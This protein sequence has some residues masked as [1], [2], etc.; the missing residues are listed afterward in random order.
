MYF[1]NSKWI[2]TTATGAIKDISDILSKALHDVLL[3]V[4]DPSGAPYVANWNDGFPEEVAQI[5]LGIQKMV[6]AKDCFV[7]AAVAERDKPVKG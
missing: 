4:E 2:E 7:R 1:P 5:E 6:E 3:I